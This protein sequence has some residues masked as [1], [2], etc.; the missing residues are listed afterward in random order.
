MSFDCSTLVTP[1]LENCCLSEASMDM[2]ASSQR[3]AAWVPH[4]SRSGRVMTF[5]TEIARQS[6]DFMVL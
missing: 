2:M 1:I 4:Q 3:R 5:I 6:G